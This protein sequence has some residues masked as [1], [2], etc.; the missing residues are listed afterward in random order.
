[1]GA[2]PLWELIPRR[3]W[4][5]ATDRAEREHSGVKEADPAA[6]YDAHAGALY[7]YLL[8]LLGDAEDAEDAFQEDLWENSASEQTFETLVVGTTA[9]GITGLTVG[10]A[11]WLLHGGS[12]LAGMVSA[13]PAWC[14]FDPLPVLD[15]FDESE[16]R[17]HD[18]DS[19]ESLV[20][21]A[22]HKPQPS[23]EN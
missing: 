7:R 22:N 18:D 9:V 14:S 21:G 4:A 5:R 20:A 13:L 8:A 3:A 23:R 19:L 6:V 17:H 11:F 1:M 16:D 15:K 2:E 12:L 10:Y